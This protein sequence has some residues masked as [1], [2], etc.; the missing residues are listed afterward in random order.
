M[1]GLEQHGQHLAPQIRGPNLLEHTDLAARGLPGKKVVINTSSNGKP[2]EFGTYTGPDPD[3]AYPCQSESD[4]RTCVAL[5]IPPTT[6]VAAERWG[7]PDDV[8][9]LAREHHAPVA[10]GE[11]GAD[12]QV[13]LVNDGPV[14]IPLRLN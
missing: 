8:R 4:P 14:T 5:G 13:E 12:M 6:E 11:F 3:D 2:F 9:A 7:L 1:P 10:C